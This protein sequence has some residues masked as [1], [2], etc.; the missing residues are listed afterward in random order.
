MT[1]ATGTRPC[2]GSVLRQ[3]QGGQAARQTHGI[4]CGGQVGGA[5][6]Q[7]AIQVKQHRLNIGEPG[8]LGCH[9][10]RLA[11]FWVASR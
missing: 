5:V 8:A 3:R 10:G 1:L 9:V 2:H 6:D 11:G 7:R 4:G